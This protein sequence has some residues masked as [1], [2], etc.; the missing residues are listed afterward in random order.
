MLVWH[1]TTLMDLL[2]H[3]S[4][5][6]HFYCCLRYQ[7]WSRWSL[8][9]T[10]Y[11]FIDSSVFCS[12]SYT[13]FSKWFGT[14]PVGSRVPSIAENS[15]QIAENYT[16]TQPATGANFTT[17]RQMCICFSDQTHSYPPDRRIS[18]AHITDISRDTR[19]GNSSRAF[20]IYHRTAF[21][22]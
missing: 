4:S 16:K 8:F 10:D 19:T 14:L 17:A 13:T 11:I 12:K 15:V 1:I 2:L 6:P 22:Q 21:H 7:F 18:L 9:V 3:I 20:D 5:L